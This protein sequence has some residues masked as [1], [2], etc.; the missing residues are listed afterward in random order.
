MKR[1][2]VPVLV[3]LLFGCKQ[4]PDVERLYGKWY[5]T[6]LKSTDSSADNPRPEELEI[7]KPYIE[8][9]RPDSLL[10]MWGG[11]IVTS[12]HFKMEGEDIVYTGK[13]P[14]GKDRTFPFRVVSYTDKELVFRTLGKGSYVVTA[15]R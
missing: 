15:R 11:L 13:A 6:S 9:I 12:G 3:L 8:L 1:L 4:S 10:I 5:Y 2:L 7:N 14:G